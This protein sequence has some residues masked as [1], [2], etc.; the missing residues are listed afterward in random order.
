MYETPPAP[1]PRRD[2]VLSKAQ[3][4]RI[5]LAAQGFTDRRPSGAATMRHV[6]RVVDRVGVVQID[7][8]NVLSRSHYLPFFSRLGPYDR[9]LPDRAAT[10][11]GGRRLVEYWAHEASLVPPETQ[12]LLRWRMARAR[13]EA[14]GAMR[15]VAVDHGDLVKAV[16]EE[17]ERH[18]PATSREI[19][20]A[21]EH[22]APRPKDH[23][24]WN[25][26]LV[27]RALEYLFW[28]GEI[29]AD[30]R[31]PQFERRYDLVSRVLPPEVHTAP[32]PDPDDARRELVRI[33][34]RA[35][36]VATEPCLRDYF[37]LKS[38]P[39]RAAVADLVDS[40][41]LVPVRVEGWDAPAYL[42]RDAR[43]P[44]RVEAR[45]LLSPFDSLVWERNR[46]E[47]LFGFR[48][49]LEIY[50]PAPKRVHGYYVLPFLLGD[51]LVAR[52]DLKAD[53]A[54]GRL[55]ARRTTL[56]PDAPA[57]TS[58]ALQAELESMASWLGLEDGVTHAR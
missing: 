37:R 38:G 35:H 47:A 20:A 56:E 44:R 9:E 27:K 12:R 29:T 10:R 4:R 2:S 3:A 50:V 6:Q 31:T 52:V 51:R 45:A 58:A 54:A 13:D 15:E 11:R 18:G 23:W 41:E 14:W 49:R 48:Y 32:D 46:T 33:A 42:H 34:A 28:C 22:D 36:G 43:V 53:R 17:V 8:V 21:L 19:E 25:W 39:G 55:L 7:S 16:R 40:G 24:G 57:A 26:S 1:H 30:G 5:A